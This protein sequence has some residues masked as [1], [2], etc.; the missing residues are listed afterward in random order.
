M[1]SGFHAYEKT[2]L[3]LCDG[4][5]YDSVGYVSVAAARAIKADAIELSWYP[6]T[7]DRFHEVKVI[8]PRSE[9]I[10]CTECPSYDEKPRIF[11]RRNWINNLHMKTYSVFALIDAIGVKTALANGTLTRHKL[12]KLRD[13]IDEIATR[14]PT[15]AFVSFAD[16]LLVKSNWRVGHW[17][18][19]LTYS[20][21]PEFI[22]RL[23]P[24]I[25]SAYHEILDMNIYAVIAQ[26]NNEYYDDNLL[27]ISASQNHI[28]LNSLGLP[29]S[30]ILAIDSAA[31][32]AIRNEEHEPADV[33]MDMNF[34]HS[35]Q[36][37]Y[38]F[39]KRERQKHAYIAPMTTGSSYYFSESYQTLLDNLRPAKAL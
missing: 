21:E 36:F 31:R 38:T 13:R 32:T 5:N 30:Q 26:G 12:I 10:T 15:L 39:K 11:I 14:Y 16:N 25:S 3:S 22:L 17:D 20:Y 4:R 7:Y 28:S 29:F 6:N 19:K 33:Y 24:E 37:D 27:H 18:S 1:R 34:F 2:L 23:L 35:L 8:L 9:F